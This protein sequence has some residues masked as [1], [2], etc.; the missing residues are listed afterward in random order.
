MR[1]GLHL[2]GKGAAVLGCEGCRRGHWYHKLF[3]LVAHGK[4]TGNTQ[5]NT[6][7]NTHPKKCSPIISDNELKCVCLNARSI[8]N[9]KYI[10]KYEITLKSEADC[11]VSIWCNIVTRN[12]T[13]TI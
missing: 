9:K 2:T 10:Q 12:S 8:V 11:E 13:L 4:L 5:R 3:K 6:T 1:D 7:A